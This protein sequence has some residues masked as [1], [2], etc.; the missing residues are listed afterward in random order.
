MKKIFAIALIAILALSLLTACGDN[1]GGDTNSGGDSKQDAGVIKASEL[2]SLEDA[3]RILGQEVAVDEKKNDKIDKMTP[4]SIEIL[5]DSIDTS[6]IRYISV[7]LYQ[8]ALLDPNSLAGKG[9]LDT[10]GISSYNARIK[11]DRESKEGAL[12]ID[13]VGDWA[14]ITAWESMGRRVG[15]IE[16]AYG[17]YCIAVTINGSPN[18][19]T[20]SE[21][22]TVAWQN[23]KLTDAGKLALERLAAIVG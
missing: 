12:V 19:E 17:D 2:I 14:C 9:L 10:G 1:S 8:N 20:A 18:Y 11:T 13:G 23:G 5:Y 3:A 7:T 16:I 15:T 21:E 6:S 22:E 4:G